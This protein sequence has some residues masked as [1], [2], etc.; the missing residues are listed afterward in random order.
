MRHLAERDIINKVK[1]LYVS[2]EALKKILEFYFQ[3]GLN[4][5][6]LRPAAKDPKG[7]LKSWKKYQKEKLYKDVDMACAD[8]FTRLG[9]VGIVCGEISDN[10][11][12]IDFDNEDLYY[13]FLEAIPPEIKEIVEKTTIV[14]TK[15]GFHIWLKGDGFCPE[16][17]KIGKIDIKG[18]P[19]LVVA[20]PSIH[21]DFVRY[22]F[23]QMNPIVRISEQ[24]YNIIYETICKIAEGECK[25]TKQ[26]KDIETKTSLSDELV[27]EIIKVIS[28]RYVPGQ[29]QD[30]CLYLS[31]LLR[32]LG[33]TQE[34]VEHII[35]KIAEATNDE[36]L[37][38][39]LDAVKYTFLKDES[40]IAHSYLADYLGEDYK[41]LLDIL[42][43]P[44][45][46]AFIPVK[47][48]ILGKVWKDIERIF[49]NEK[50]CKVYL[51]RTVG[52]KDPYD[53]TEPLFS[54]AV[55]PLEYYTDIA[56]NRP[57]YKITIKSQR[58]E[59]ELKGYS[60]ELYNELATR[61]YILNPTK[62]PSY[63][64]HILSVAKFKGEVLLQKGFFRGYVNY[65]VEYSEEDLKMALSDLIKLY[66]FFKKNKTQYHFALLFRWALI[67]P[68][69]PTIKEFN[70]YVKNIIL[71]GVGGTGKTAMS[72]I[73]LKMF[74]GEEYEKNLIFAQY[75]E[76]KL[77]EYLR[78]NLLPIVFDEGIKLFLDNRVG[79]IIKQATTSNPVFKQYDRSTN[80]FIDVK[81]PAPG[82]IF[83]F[84]N[85]K[86]ILDTELWDL[87]A[88]QR[89]FIILYFSKENI[90]K[91]EDVK[92]FNDLFLQSDLTP[93]GKFIINKIK[94]LWESDRELLI[95]VDEYG[96]PLASKLIEELDKVFPLPPEFKLPIR[97]LEEKCKIEEGVSEVEI[98][99]SKI[100][101]YLVN[102]AM[103]YLNIQM[104][105]SVEELVK[106]YLNKN[107]SPY[108]KVSK[109]GMYVYILPT[110]S[111][112]VGISLKDIANMLGG[113]Y[114]KHKGYYRVKLLLSDF[115]ALLGIEE[116]K[117]EID[118]IIETITKAVDNK[119]P[120]DLYNI[121]PQL[122]EK[123]IK[124]C[125]MYDITTNYQ[126]E[127]QILRIEPNH[128][129]HM[130]SFVKDLYNFIKGG[131]V[132]G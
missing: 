52:K 36:E 89:R 32:R 102:D 33:Y 53:I 10:F 8:I 73:M 1:E 25:K 112:E 100:Y 3:E 93:I 58:E 98:L 59:L 125:N 24:T 9:N 62:C 50:T 92:A 47:Y 109:D 85:L 20:P 39:R 115:L 104:Y 37:Q 122:A 4:V 43:K 12:A 106:A 81:I 110:F 42:K 63:F 84:N 19:S 48:I 131:D 67:S 90:P 5:L 105:D 14:K 103:K 79:D 29:R 86:P 94:E 40:E 96:E 21:P 22:E 38:R 101:E 16:S 107:A 97:E 114:K 124:V 132:N 28:K 108:F 111:K 120:V 78:S 68:V 45:H 15:R 55:I 30:I 13:K 46:Y 27:D 34:Q 123:V 121:P 80:T 113:E 7:I 83:T 127:F 118:E 2:K 129:V 17:T 26:C 18:Q 119:D 95:N 91:P 51:S 64:A 75:S 88:L 126:Q 77:R 66:A 56:T 82:L 54:C 69:F 11:F 31:G 116:E 41:K 76:A 57:V 128:R 23:Y 70:R 35:T 74:L 61:N 49:I 117:D 130:E 60:D 65:D 87:N 71:A 72:K 44:K 99:K 6:P